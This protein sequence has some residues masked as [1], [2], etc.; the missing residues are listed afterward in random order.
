MVRDVLLRK[1][2]NTVFQLVRYTFVGGFSFV[3]DFAVLYLFTHFL[4]IHYLVSA[5]LGFLMGLVVNYFLSIYWVFHCRTEQSR[6]RE[7]VWFALIGL[8]GLGMNELFIWIFTEKAGVHYLA[9]K[10]ITTAFVYFWNFFARK[11]L[12]FN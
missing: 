10:L 3:V 5:G 4:F 8:V 9:S 12:L 2:D 6:W 1:T 7:F 11:Y